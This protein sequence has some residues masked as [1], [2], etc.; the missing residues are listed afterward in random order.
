MANTLPSVKLVPNQW[1]DIYVVTGIAKGTKIAVQNIGA[2]DVYLAVSLLEPA[3]E[4]DFFQ[5]I[6]PNDFPMANS[7]D[8]KGAWAFSANSGAKINVRIVP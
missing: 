3:L 1:T 8:D 6:Q 2:S 5:V 4:S 7:Q